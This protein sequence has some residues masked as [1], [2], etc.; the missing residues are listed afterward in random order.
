MQ[1]C[2]ST[3]PTTEILTLSKGT[4]IMELEMLPKKCDILLYRIL[5]LTPLLLLLTPVIA[6]RAPRRPRI[7]ESLRRWS[8]SDRTAQTHEVVERP[9]VAMGRSHPQELRVPQGLGRPHL[10]TK[11]ILA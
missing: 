4:K 3:S 2:I 7:P 11:K 8:D 9:V 6:P 10:A 5:P 1:I